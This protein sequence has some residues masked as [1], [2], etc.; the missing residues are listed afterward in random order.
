MKYNDD[1]ISGFPEIAMK[2]DWSPHYKSWKFF[3]VTGMENESESELLL[4]YCVP[5]YSTDYTCSNDVN[6]GIIFA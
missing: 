6:R 1:S 2:G 4:K 3:Y 5:N